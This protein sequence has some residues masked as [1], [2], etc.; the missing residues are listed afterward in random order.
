MI[1]H[2]LLITFKSTAKESEINALKASFESMPLKIEGVH[3]VEWGLNDSQ[4]G[5]N[6]NY[7]H[8]VLMNFV[9]AAGR[10]NYLPHPEHD[11]LKKLFGPILED[12]I[13]FDY[14]L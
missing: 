5:K 10:D 2:I 6:K 9:D 1:R 7:T 12:L 3:S 8:A 14:T 11:E 13:V 4:E